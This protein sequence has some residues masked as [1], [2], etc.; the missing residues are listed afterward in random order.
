MTEAEDRNGSGVPHRQVEMIQVSED[1]AGMRLDR[2]LRRRRPGLTQGRAEKLLRTGQVRVDG[3]R[4]KSA[5]RLET[6]QTVRLPPESDAEDAVA[7]ARKA[8]PGRAQAYRADPRDGAALRQMILHEDE[9][10]LA[11]AKPIGLAVQGGSGVKRHLDGM[12]TALYGEDPDRRPKLV[13]RLD[14]DTSGVLLLAKTG[15]AARQLTAAFKGREARKVYWALVVGQPPEV[16]GRISAPLAKVPGPKGERMEVN[17]DIGDR[18][19]TDFRMIDKALDRFTWLEMRPLTGRTHQL[20]VHCQQM[21]TPI[22]GDGKYGGLDALEEAGDLTK[23]L[24]LHAR[25]LVLPHPAGGWLRVAA[26]APADYLKTLKYLGFAPGD[27]PD[28]FEDWTAL[29]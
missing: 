4:A 11:L 13:H 8:G 25:G 19:V 24:Y 27:A 5:Q 20:R 7:Q 3:R 23:R 16:E 14:R 10:V 18:A 17:L 6:G 9:M 1:D 21:G 22:L 29:P 28:P 12:I 2:W 15:K 26:P